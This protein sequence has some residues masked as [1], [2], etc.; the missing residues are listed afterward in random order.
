MGG[1]VAGMWASE[2]QMRKPDWL[3]SLSSSCP[4]FSALFEIIRQMQMIISTYFPKMQSAS[5]NNGEQ[6]VESPEKII[7]YRLT[8]VMWTWGLHGSTNLQNHYLLICNC[9]C[10]FIRWVIH[11]TLHEAVYSVHSKSS[12]STSWIPDSI[13]FWNLSSYEHS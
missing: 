1:E 12:L 8:N 11:K 6:Y 2:S 7:H 13:L 3:S 10:S 5:L 9:I 4:F